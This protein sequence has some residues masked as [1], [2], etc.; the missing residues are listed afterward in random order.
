[1]DPV[2]VRH[3]QHIHSHAVSLLRETTSPRDVDQWIQSVQSDS[4][5]DHLK[6]VSSGMLVLI[7][8]R[9]QLYAKNNPLS[10]RLPFEE[11]DKFLFLL[12][13]EVCVQ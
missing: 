5:V 6:H 4:H 1:V 12:N 11:M 13:S 3:V 7:R 2:V 9:F 10:S 8:V